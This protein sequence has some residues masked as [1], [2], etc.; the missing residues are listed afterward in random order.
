[1]PLVLEVRAQNNTVDYTTVNME[2][3]FCY[4]W[5]GGHYPSPVAYPTIKLRTHAVSSEWRT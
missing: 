4:C 2:E 1:M 5:L 3:R